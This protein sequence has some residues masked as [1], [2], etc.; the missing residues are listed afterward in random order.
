M[1]RGV[2]GGFSTSLLASR[3]SKSCSYRQSS[4]FMK[5]IGSEIQ[6]GQLPHCFLSLCSKAKLQIP[7]RLC[8]Q[9]APAG[10]HLHAIQGAKMATDTGNCS[11]TRHRRSQIEFCSLRSLA[12]ARL[13]RPRKC[14]FLVILG[15]SEQDQHC[16]D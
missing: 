1:G 10:S 8:C 15:Y 11:L 6:P 5:R 7:G 14:C 12:E 2:G 9:I 3:A 16:G 13:E 4:I